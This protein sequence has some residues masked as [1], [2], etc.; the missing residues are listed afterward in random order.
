MYA[1]RVAGQHRSEDASL[2]KIT[3]R[4]AVVIAIPLV[5]DLQ[6]E[7]TGEARKDFVHVRQHAMN[8]LGIDFA[9]RH[10]H[11]RGGGKLLDVL[12]ERLVRV[13]QRERS[14]HIQI[15]SL[16]GHRKQLD[17][18]E[19]LQHG[20]VHAMH[21]ANDHPR[22]GLTHQGNGIT[23]RMMDN[24]HLVDALVRLTLS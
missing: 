24:L 8:L 11:T 10:G 12:L 20:I 3:E 22:V 16:L 1:G 13:T 9:I 15:S 17:N 4:A 2:S 7:P 18:A 6:V 5:E 23:R 14:R 21:V 19:T